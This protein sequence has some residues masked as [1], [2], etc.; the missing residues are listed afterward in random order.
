M[1][2]KMRTDATLDSW[3]HEVRSGV[4]DV[5]GV[6]S[7]LRSKCPGVAEEFIHFPPLPSREGKNLYVLAVLKALKKIGLDSWEVIRWRDSSNP[8]A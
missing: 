5:K 2:F 3:F 6:F 7:K 4:R 8:K 1:V